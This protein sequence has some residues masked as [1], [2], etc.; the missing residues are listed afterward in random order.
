[1]FF[2]LYL[3]TVF[4]A[5]SSRSNNLT[6]EKLVGNSILIEY[7]LAFNVY[8][9]NGLSTLF[10]ISQF[11][12][13]HTIQWYTIVYLSISKL[14]TIHLFTNRNLWDNYG[15]RTIWMQ[16]FQIEFCFAYGY[17]AKGNLFFV[18]FII[19]VFTYL[20]TKPNVEVLRKHWKY[21]CILVLNI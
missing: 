4:K 8:F 20:V 6:W 9:S 3:L 5:A 2:C 13:H 15:K 18:C 7:Q 21:D 14:C 16:R 10:H 17:H 19:V 11:H 1:M 12:H